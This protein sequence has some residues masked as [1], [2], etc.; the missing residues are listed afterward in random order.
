[1]EVLLFILDKKVAHQRLLRQSGTVYEEGNAHPERNECRRMGAATVRGT[2]RPD[3]LRHHPQRGP[4][5]VQRGLGGRSYCRHALQ[6]HQTRVELLPQ[7]RVPRHSLQGRRG[8]TL[9]LSRSLSLRQLHHQ[10][11]RRIPL[12]RA[13]QRTTLNVKNY[14]FLIHFT[15]SL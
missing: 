14:K 5:E 9:R 2:L 4:G 12:R 15:I 3:L 1:M 7:R 8:R 6:P 11:K 10:G 13:L